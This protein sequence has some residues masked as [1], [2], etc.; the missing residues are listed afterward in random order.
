MLIDALRRFNTVEAWRNGFFGLAW[1]SIGYSV[2]NFLFAG[3]GTLRNPIGDGII[4]A[5]IRQATNDGPM[6]ALI[7][8]FAMAIAYLPVIYF[9]VKAGKV[10]AP[11]SK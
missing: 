2:V 6:V 11:K 3:G 9:W 4:T 1:L 8:I 10:C 5:Y 7:G